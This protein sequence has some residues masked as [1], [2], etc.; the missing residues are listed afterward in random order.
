MD[1]LGTAEREKVPAPTVAAPARSSPAPH[2]PVGTRPSRVVLSPA[3]MLRVQRTA[4]NRAAR[5]A[6]APAR[7]PV[8]PVPVAPAPADS[9]VAGPAPDVAPEAELAVA[10]D[11]ATPGPATGT[12]VAAR[13]DTPA[14][15]APPDPALPEPVLPDLR[16]EPAAPAR[17]R[18]VQRDAADP[19]G[20]QDGGGGLLGGIRARIEG[21]VGGLRSGWQQL[22]DTAG[23]AFGAV[24]EQVRSAAS[25]LAGVGGSLVD[26]LRG[27]LA[28]A[29]QQARGALDAVTG[30]LRAGLSAVTG[31]VG[32]LGAALRSLDMDAAAAAWARLTGALGAVGQRVQQGVGALTGRLSG[33]GTAL[34]ARMTAASDG[35]ATRARAVEDTARRAA[36][37][38]QER[39]TAAWAQLS[40]RGSTLSDL[41]ARVPSPL[42]SLVDSVLAGGRR[43]WDGIR[44]KAGELQ[45]RAGALAEDVTGR[46]RSAAEG[47]RTRLSGV[48]SGVQSA[49]STVKAT[50]SAAA[51]RLVEGVGAA[52][53]R[54]QGLNLLGPLKE[55]GKVTTLV[56]DIGRVAADPKAAI[57]P[58]AQQ[59]AQMLGAG[60]PAAALDAGRARMAAGPDGP[61][62]DAGGPTVQ[63]QPEPGTGPVRSTAWGGIW[64]GIFK[65]VGDKWDAVKDRKLEVVLE[66]LYTFFWPWSA[67]KQEIVGVWTDWKTTAGSLFAPKGLTLDP[68]GWLHDIWTNLLK[69]MDFPFALLRRLS[70]VLLLLVGPL[71]ILL[72]I[73]GLVGGTLAGTVIGAILGA[74]GGGIPAAATTPA[75][76]LAGGA[77]GAGVGF[78]AGLAIGEVAVALFLATQSGSLWKS[79]VELSTAGL[80]TEEKARIFSQCADNVIAIG[81]T[82]VLAILGALGARIGAT[83]A[84]FVG[85]FLPAWLTEAAAKFAAGV[86]G[87]R[88][89]PGT[90]TPDEK[91]PEP[92]PELAGRAGVTARANKLA[93]QIAKLRA[94]HD[95]ARGGDAEVGRR[96][97]AGE[98][99]A[100]DLAS[101]SEKATTEE[102]LRAVEKEVKAAEKDLFDLE[103][104]VGRSELTARL[105]DL[106]EAIR[107]LRAR[108]RRPADIPQRPEPQA[109]LK[110]VT[111][112]VEAAEAELAK[113]RRDTAGADSQRKVERAREAADKLARDVEN[114]QRNNNDPNVLEPSEAAKLGVSKEAVRQMRVIEEKRVN[115]LGEENAQANHNHYDA[116]RKEARG[117]VVK[118][119]G[120][121]KPFDHIADLQQARDAVFNARRLLQAE[122]PTTERGIKVV[123]EK[124][125]LAGKLIR[126]VDE[127]L[128]EIG[129]PSSRPHVWVESPEG[130]GKWVPK[131]DVPAM[132]PRINQ[133]LRVEI[134]EP[135]RGT[136]RQVLQVRDPARQAR[137]TADREA[138]VTE[139]EAIR[140]RAATATEE[141]QLR[142]ADTDTTRLKGRVDTFKTQLAGVDAPEPSGA[143]R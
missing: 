137:L 19:A 7:R 81:V 6:L 104:G 37:A 4:G 16:L 87:A 41:A 73:L 78:A 28:G 98:K 23:K 2:G 22:G 13:P 93:E 82:I 70:S 51:G 121:G 33:L 56:R 10:L 86:K 71:T 72:T 18:A 96:L 24:G 80:T 57:M 106:D 103:V 30:G 3:A 67:I 124:I 14:D 62:A 102:Q 139:T 118:A 20:G 79:L 47:V 135:M 129:W 119:R 54:I 131:A 100:R 40:G 130:S 15:A 11:A 90:P 46:L 61:A 75:G 134:E 133:R 97:E 111:A 105:N 50:A 83:V 138:I 68:I 48:W 63:R 35:L 42:R 128:S 114:L 125:E 44:S 136:D 26:G 32:A 77:T 39:V 1:E 76:T 69:L 58:Y 110:K 94:R 99:A 84:A 65:A 38:V 123:I 143:T 29:Q 17:G 142:Q 27:A 34:D 108:L 122:H 9:A 116:A 127:F 55:A 49:W 25:G 91:P 132:R 89:K 92:L 66:G 36:A 101:R 85:K 5:Q 115:P 112:E 120:D 21:V 52:R 31:A 140:Q 141:A 88:T 59:V 74:L 8:A 12:A 43:L 126:R 117:E 53:G 113:L 95:A 60:M 45:Q 107:D 109:K 64:S